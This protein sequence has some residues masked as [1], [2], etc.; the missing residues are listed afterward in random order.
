MK[1]KIGLFSAICALSIGMTG[2]GDVKAKSP[3]NSSAPAGSQTEPAQTENSAPAD[4][5]QPSENEQSSESESQSVLPDV[6]SSDDTLRDGDYVRMIDYVSESLHNNYPLDQR[7][8]ICTEY[9]STNLKF[10]GGQF[11]VSCMN[12]NNRVTAALCYSGT[13]K[14][15]DDEL[16]FNYQ[17]L[18]ID[19]LSRASNEIELYGD[20]PMIDISMNQEY[21]ETDRH[22]T[23]Y[24]KMKTWNE[25]GS[26]ACFKNAISSLSAIR[27]GFNPRVFPILTQCSSMVSNNVWEQLPPC[28][29]KVKN[30]FLCI[31]TYGSSVQGKYARGKAFTI[32]YNYKTAMEDC[33]Y[34]SLYQTGGTTNPELITNMQSNLGDSGDRYD[35]T[36]EFAN[37]EWTWRN[38]AGELINNG[39]YTESSK[40]P[41]LIEMQITD[42]SAV[43]DSNYISIRV[44]F[45]IADNGKIY[46]PAF[47]KAE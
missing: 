37:G 41:G 12:S 46:Y 18:H 36:V 8:E 17:N 32:N 20:P 42:Q 45:Y 7:I 21:Q 5:G 34:S 16:Q 2:C 33:L 31:D 11:Q 6:F 15:E 22:F 30:D 35:T 43:N 47:V 38:S 23:D 19:F 26:F 14:Q 1:A 24:M 27:N 4:T 40:Y 9:S 28:I 39:I 3:S 25:S 13:M 10:S 29:L 44:I